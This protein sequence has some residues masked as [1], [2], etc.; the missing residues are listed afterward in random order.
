LTGTAFSGKRNP[1]NVYHDWS[2]GLLASSPH[3][4]VPGPV[5]LAEVAR[6]SGF[7]LA[8][9]SR[10]LNPDSSHPV[11]EATRRRV[12]EAADTLGYRLN[13]LARGLKNR[14]S[15][16]VGVIV[17][18]I[19]DPYF[20]ECARGVANA[21]ESTGFL[22]F[23]CNSDRRP[24]TELRYVEMLQENR[25][26]GVLFVG[27]GFENAT[28]RA[29]LRGHI[30]AIRD[31]GGEAIALGPRSDRLPAEVPDNRGG[32]RQGTEHLIQLGH[33][34]IAYIDGP[35]GLKTSS[36]RLAGYRDAIEAAG[37]P[38]DPELVLPGD[39]SEI[40]GALATRALLESG[41][42]FTAIFSSNDIT[43]L[44]CRQV[45]GEFGLRAPDD[46]SLVGFD[47]IPVVRWLN[48]PLTTVA[49]PMTEIGTAGMQRLIALLE[50]DESARR[51]RR[52]NV[53]PTQL[54]VRGST[55]PPRRTSERRGR[56]A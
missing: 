2:G 31:Y 21:A 24:E 44:G 11:S 22:T 53:H 17:H 7:S 5:S 36:A 19:R 13:A 32:A 34:R 28:Y 8:T 6:R 37:L 14:R 30:A 12:A 27:G 16:T 15:R 39:F 23:I 55:G 47:D 4:R 1:E 48:P 45:L 49:V 40:G 10:A 38:F 54:V 41:I 20:N 33:E 35:A 52:V 25:A 56:R 51:M 18:D 3:G 46:V 26:A 29:E 9:A 42:D 43:V 50:G